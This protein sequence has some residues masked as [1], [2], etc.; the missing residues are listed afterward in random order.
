MIVLIASA[1]AVA[2]SYSSSARE[3]LAAIQ[4]QPNEL[5]RYD[6]LTKAMPGLSVRDQG[7]AQQFVS[8]S[9]NEL[10]IYSQ[11]VLSF[12][13]KSRNAADM[14]IPSASEWKAVDAVDAISAL[15]AD[16]RVVLIN[17]AHHNAHTR[18]LT[19]ELLPRL[20]AM[21]F[22]HFAAEALGDNDTELMKRGY[23]VKTTGTEYL[24]EPLYGEMVRQAIRL[25]FIIVPYDTAGTTAQAR[26]SGQAE[27]LYRRALA[28]DPHARL[29]VHAGYAHIDKAKGRLHAFEPMAMRLKELTGIDPLSID[30]VQFLEIGWELDD[31]YH[32]MTSRF[33]SASPEVL[34]NRISG[35]PWTD[36]PDRYDINVILPPSLDLKAFGDERN[37]HTIVGPIVASLITMQR[38][39]W[40]TLGGKRQAFQI[41]T[42]LCRNITPCVV[43]AYYPLE[44]DS[45]AP[46]DRY[47]FMKSGVTTK[48]Y[49]YPGSYR[50]RAWDI[51]GKTLSEQTIKVT[52]R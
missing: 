26:E 25:G 1:P 4:R 35:L 40:L 34:M 31:P 10:G 46:A 38:P 3:L 22:T 2:Q 6:Y 29:F 30:Q 48:L 12:P 42:A 5:A 20:R 9:Q 43:D 11:A 13:L 7:L 18:E 28:K 8:F 39:G 44:P 50:L 51:A 24:Y 33:P 47:A 17:E 52:G 14:V 16:R 41:D 23:P 19:L 32:Q 27:N 49:L 21:G 37:I 15:A 36:Q 45:A